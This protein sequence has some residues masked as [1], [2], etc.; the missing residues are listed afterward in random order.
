MLSATGSRRHV[1]FLL[2]ACFQQ[3]MTVS[4]QP[5][6]CLYSSALIAKKS[7]QACTRPDAGLETFMV[8]RAKPAL[9][10]FSTEGT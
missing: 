6:L 4:W 3:R 2:L 9:H 5:T 10:D 1:T 8:L 7:P